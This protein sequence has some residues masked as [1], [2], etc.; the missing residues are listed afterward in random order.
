MAQ[1]RCQMKK[2]QIVM[3]KN[4][5]GQILAAWKK[6][7]FSTVCQKRFPMHDSGA[8]RYI[9]VDDL[10]NN[11]CSDASARLHVLGKILVNLMLIHSLMTVVWNACCTCV[12]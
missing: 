7:P 2:L 1:D 3:G 4:T 11:F 5:C 9:H 10:S 8:H 6:I 12:K